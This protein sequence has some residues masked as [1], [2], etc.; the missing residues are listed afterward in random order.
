MV[1]VGIWKIALLLL[2]LSLLSDRG[3]S[4]LS[5]DKLQRIMTEMFN[6]FDQQALI[7][8]MEAIN[9]KI[10]TLKKATG[11]QYSI[12][13]LLSKD[14]CENG[15]LGNN[16]PADFTEIRNTLA[17]ENVYKQ[18]N[19][20]AAI[21]LRKYDQKNKLKGTDHAEYRVL[22][23]LDQQNI[24]PGCLIIYTYFSPCFAK[25]LN[26][27]SETNIIYLLNDL[28]NQNQNTDIALVFSS[29]FHHDRKSNTKDQIYEKLKEI[30]AV[31]VYC[32][33]KE[34]GNVTC[35]MFDR[36]KGKD[37]QCLSQKIETDQNTVQ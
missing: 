14:A 4:A 37:Q 36:N 13:L 6:R 10:K 29:L 26:D 5:E 33:Y 34:K 21:P 22:E 28:K 8:Q 11:K 25:C 27:E 24:S 32:C 12:A 15:Q 2:S 3:D 17:N 1:G 19:V 7:Q 35:A 31:P 30:T 23:E 18:D 9:K 16:I 20:V